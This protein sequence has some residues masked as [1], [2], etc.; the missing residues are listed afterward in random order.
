VFLNSARCAGSAVLK[1]KARG[2]RLMT[3]AAERAAAPEAGADLHQRVGTQPSRLGHRGAEAGVRGGQNPFEPI[4]AVRPPSA[5]GRGHGDAVR[6]HGRPQHAHRIEDDSGRCGGEPVA[7]EAGR[8]TGG[9]VRGGREGTATLP[10]Q[11]PLRE[12]SRRSR[13]TGVEMLIPHG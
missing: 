4:A 3:V 7:I 13:Q 11:A 10:T 6:P 12:R 9:A 2:V 8:A 5:D 1:K